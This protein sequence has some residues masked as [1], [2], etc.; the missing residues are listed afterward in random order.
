[1]SI[2]LSK[3]GILTVGWEPEP[4]RD[5]EKGTTTVFAHHD[6]SRNE[7]ILLAQELLAFGCKYMK[8]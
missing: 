8:P 1:M 7:A 2:K 3:A 5:H 6:L 4:E